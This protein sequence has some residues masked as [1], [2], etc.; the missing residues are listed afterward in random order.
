MKE[1]N[2]FLD[3]PFVYMIVDENNVPLFI[4]AATQLEEK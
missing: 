2:I 4:G 3:K 1:I